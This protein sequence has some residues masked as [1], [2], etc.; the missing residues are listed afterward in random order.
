MSTAAVLARGGELNCHA[1]AH[2]SVR[3]YIRVPGE[4]D[5]TAGRQN[6]KIIIIIF[7]FSDRP[8]AST[9]S[10]T[11]T[12]L[13]LVLNTAAPV[14]PR[15]SYHSVSKY[16]DILCIK[17]RYKRYLYTGCAPGTL[18]T[19]DILLIILLCC[20]VIRLRIDGGGNPF[21]AEET[22]SIRH[23]LQIKCRCFVFLVC[24]VWGRG[25]TAVK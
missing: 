21:L 7:N 14:S 10:H 24:C 19:S 8:P 6:N 11:W 20:P 23:D 18:R 4:G 15:H 1:R 17:T 16:K 25:D 9:A 13:A 22:S 3:I 2:Q 12:L 5:D